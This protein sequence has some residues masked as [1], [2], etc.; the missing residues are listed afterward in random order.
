M[1]ATGDPHLERIHDERF[2]LM[3]LGNPVLLIIPELMLADEAL[4]RVAGRCAP[5][6]KHLCGSVF[7]PNQCY[8]L[9]GR[10]NAIWRASSRRD[11]T[12]SR[13]SGT[14]CL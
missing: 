11:E 10:G 9:L 14:V 8:G 7:R 5:N 6:W 13:D 3:K 4:L 12:D 1:V 2:D